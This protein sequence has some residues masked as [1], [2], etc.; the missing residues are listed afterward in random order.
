MT[1]QYLDVKTIKIER[2]GADR[3]TQLADLQTVT[4][5]QAYSDVHSLEDIETYCRAHFTPEIAGIDLSSEET[6]CC[7]GLLDSEP[8]GYYMV[9]HQ[10]C[11]I[12]IGSESSELKQLYVLRSAYGG[13]LGRYLY[14]HAL[15]TIRS[16]G[17]LL[18]WLCVSDINYRAQAFY[19]KQGFAKLGT[20]PVLEVGKEKLAS[21]ILVSVSQ[22][23]WR[24]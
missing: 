23:G 11:P 5:K 22:P 2:I 21:S 13:G 8:S 6:V 19:D 12:A 16:T 9:K 4:F 14:E 20:G 10:A 17:H 7:V 24:H 3:A 15:A 18:A 1:R